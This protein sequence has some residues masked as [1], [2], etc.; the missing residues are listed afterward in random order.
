MS[1]VAKWRGVLCNYCFYTRHKEECSGRNRW[2]PGGLC[3]YC[4]GGSP[5]HTKMMSGTVTRAEFE[6][7]TWGHLRRR[8]PRTRAR[9]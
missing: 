3:S 5:W 4:H 7:D 6:N 2:D 1:Y 8:R 9:R